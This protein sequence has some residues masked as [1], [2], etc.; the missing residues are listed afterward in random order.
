MITCPDCREIIKFDT[1]CPTCRHAICYKCDVKHVCDVETICRELERAVKRAAGDRWLVDWN[2]FS[3]V[4][5]TR[6][7]D[8]VASHDFKVSWHYVYER[9]S[10]ACALAIEKVTVDKTRR[11]SLIVHGEFTDASHT[12]TEFHVFSIPFEGIVSDGQVFFSS[13]PIDHRMFLLQ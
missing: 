5:W 8:P 9:E 7:I 11:Y 2:T 13:P 10:R 4:K 6:E 3:S 12:G 1:F